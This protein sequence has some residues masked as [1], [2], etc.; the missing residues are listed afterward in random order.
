MTKNGK[1]GVAYHGNSSAINGHRTNA[2]SQPNKGKTS[3]PQQHEPWNLFGLL[4][5]PSQP[6]SPSQNTKPLQ[7]EISWY[8][9]QRL[10]TPILSQVQNLTQPQQ[11]ARRTQSAPAAP[12]RPSPAPYAS[13]SPALYASPSPPRAT[14][15]KAAPSK[16]TLANFKNEFEKKLN[17][18]SGPS[19]NLSRPDENFINNFTNIYAKFWKD[20]DIE[21][22]PIL[23]NAVKRIE[24]KID[25]KYGY[26]TKPPI[27]NISPLG[28]VISK[29]PVLSAELYASYLDES[30]SLVDNKL[31]TENDPTKIKKL[32]AFRLGLDLEL[33][34][35]YHVTNKGAIAQSV[36]GGERDAKIHKENS[37]LTIF[38]HLSKKSQDALKADCQSRKSHIDNFIYSITPPTQ[39][40][41]LK[42][43]NSK[44]INSIQQ[45]R[46]PKTQATEKAYNLAKKTGTPSSDPGVPGQ[47]YLYYQSAERNAGKMFNEAIESAKKSVSE[48]HRA[49]NDRIHPQSEDGGFHSFTS[50]VNRRASPS[51]MRGGTRHPGRTPSH[52]SRDR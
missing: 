43:I 38:E 40:S 45:K 25:P 21:Q 34:K 5:Q 17:N 36:H 24:R 7:P 18:N 39:L 23:E 50:A 10:S 20:L 14:P 31:N 26:L 11:Q 2:P 15:P 48:L 8:D 3:K 47:A 46:S 37:Q 22:N 19:Y 42:G 33:S 13:P 29:D 30:L 51:S 9:L 44:I 4:A 27:E 41:G 16:L 6:T 28:R 35:I 32:E 49:V 1:E 12:T 52:Y